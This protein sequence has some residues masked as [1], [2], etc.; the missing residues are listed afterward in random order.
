MCVKKL[1]GSKINVV[2]YCVY[3]MKYDS[4]HGRFKHDVKVTGTDEF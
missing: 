1:I 2:G 3:Q 4:T